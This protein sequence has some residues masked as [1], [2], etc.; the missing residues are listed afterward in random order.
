MKRATKPAKGKDK[1]D[2]LTA[3]NRK[4]DAAR[5]RNEQQKALAKAKAELA[6]LTRSKTK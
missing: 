2:A 4:I 1:V 3:I 5:K 6:K